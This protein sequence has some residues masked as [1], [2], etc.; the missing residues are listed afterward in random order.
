MSAQRAPVVS[1]ALATFN[2]AAY[3][4]AQLE[5]MAAQTRVPDEIVVT[6]DRSTD[7]TAAIVA[8]F[9][10]RHPGI[11]VRFECNAERLGSTRNFEAA[12]RRCRGDIVLFSDQDD[13][14]LAERVSRAVD[15]F[16]HDPGLTY[17][18]CNGRIVDASGAHLRGTLFS[19]A[20]FTPAERAAFAAGDALRV[21]L[22]HNV[23]TGAALAVRR[24]ALERILPFEPGWIHDYFIAFML[25]ATG[26]G[27]FLEEPLIRYRR[28]AGQQVGIGGGR[29]RDA[30]AHARR[31]DE[32]HCRRD[33]G[34]F[35]ALRGRLEAVVGAQ[36]LPLLAALDEKAAFCEQ[37]AAMRAT[38]MRMP[39]M[40]WRGWR[41]GLYGRCTI[42]WKQAVVDAM[43]VLFAMA[44]RRRG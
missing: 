44:A 7:A 39:V 19:G 13:L 22:R 34:A 1:V 32:A 4:D 16:A 42:G 15:A 17:V 10:Q 8:A 25:S 31:Q 2:G 40:I 43:A 37:R 21:L 24:D 6:D 11:A 12:V 3:L 23:V 41:A 36:S 9:A 20:A 33:A 28:H 29:V 18:F 35:R 14:W 38:P 27:G 5:S 26:R 30:F